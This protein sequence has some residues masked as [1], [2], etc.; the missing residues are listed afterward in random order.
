MT[1]LTHPP[2]SHPGSTSS[3][4]ISYSPY[5]PPPCPKC[6]KTFKA[7]ANHGTVL[8]HMSS[9]IG[10]Y[11]LF[12]TVHDPG[13][14]PNQGTPSQQVG[15][16]PTST[17]TPLTST[18]PS[19]F[20]H[21]RHSAPQLPRNS[22]R[23][24]VPCPG[25]PIEWDA[26]TFYT[27]YP[28]Q[29]HAP[30][31]KN[32]APYDLMIISGIPKAR[33]PQCLGGTV[34]L[35]GIPPCAKCSRLTLDV[36]I[37]REKASRLF[38]HVRNHDDLNSTQLRAKVALVK[39]KVDTLRFKKLDLEGSLQRAQARLSEWRDLFQFIGQNPCSIPALHRLLANAEKEGWSTVP[40]SKPTSLSAIPR[41][42]LHLPST[43]YSISGQVLSLIPPVPSDS[44]DPHVQWA[45]DGGFIAFCLNK[46]KNSGEETTHRRN[47]QI[48]TSSRLIDCNIP[49]QA[50]EISASDLPD[51]VIYA[52]PIANT[53]IEESIQNRNACR[54]CGKAFKGPDR[55]QHVGEHISEFA[56][57]PLDG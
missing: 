46:K 44:S 15:A 9:C 52:S 23:W 37:I 27:T 31:A 53:A 7:G 51:A 29:L 40:G 12:R 28:F 57:Q 26:D 24:S 48:T 55:Q 36:K 4:S 32:C 35:E 42:E 1:V 13:L 22:S 20:V 11:L 45:W 56:M 34:T 5:I 8:V 38:E 33:L 18:A 6:G 47:L 16:L 19:A 2:H 3:A 41:T 50:L 25:I 17:R 43:S 54:V 39:E 30:N 49:D 10:Q 14:K 21:P